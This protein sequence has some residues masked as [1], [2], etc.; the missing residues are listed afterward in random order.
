MLTIEPN[1]VIVSR[2]GHI[3]NNGTVDIKNNGQNKNIF[4]VEFDTEIFC[5]ISPAVGEL[6]PGESRTLKFS[7]EDT[8]R[9]NE[10]L[11]FIVRYTSVSPNEKTDISEIIATSKNWPNTVK[12]V[13]K[14]SSHAEDALRSIAA[15][16]KSKPTVQQVQARSQS[17]D[18]SKE[19]L[20]MLKRKLNEK[21]NYN[22]QLKTKKTNL[23]KEIKQQQAQLKVL[24]SRTD[25]NPPYI[26]IGLA[27]L[28]AAMFLKYYR[29]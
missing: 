9:E 21:K 7:F 8:I 11:S 22:Q 3:H 13:I 18:I 19:Q 23:E 24:Q 20:D 26:F 12:C 16:T 1:P 14:F 29:K 15:V 2:T 5:G 28:L 4:S 27:L 10:E 6:V 25:S 17:R